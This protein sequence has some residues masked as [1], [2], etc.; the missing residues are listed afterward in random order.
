MGD[1]VVS[2]LTSKYQTTVPSSVRETL[3]LSRGDSIVFETGA[4][5]AVTIRKAL[6]L[7]LEL[8]RALEPL[9]SEWSSDKD[10]EAYRD[11]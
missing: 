7:D 3:G 11:L 1:R 2:K 5:G 10:E 8:A 6:P 4:D 9:L